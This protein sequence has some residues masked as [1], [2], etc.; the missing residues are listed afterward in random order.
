M[1]QS[2]ISPKLVAG[3]L[4]ALFLGV[5]LY[6]RII[7]P[8]DQV[9]TGGW[10]KL[11]GNDSHL[12]MR[13]VDNLVH[14]FPHLISLDPYLGYPKAD[15]LGGINFF[16]YFLAGIIWLVGL[17]SPTQHTVDVVSVYFPAILGA[18]TVIP[19]FFIGKALFNRWAGVLSAGLLAILPG[20]FLTRTRC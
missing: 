10:I 9:F 13:Q 17:G 1:S 3:I 5:A 20:D 14:N 12:F 19:V 15:A 4:V 7:L 8:Y 2:K 6:L 11:I 18:L 16:V